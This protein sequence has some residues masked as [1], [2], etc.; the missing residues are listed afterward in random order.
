MEC[1]CT[2]CDWTGNEPLEK[3]PRD[4][5]DTGYYY[6]PKCYGGVEWVPD[7]AATKEGAIAPP[8]VF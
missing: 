8:P 7:E 1:R 5:G 4:R 6:C 3:V 2:N